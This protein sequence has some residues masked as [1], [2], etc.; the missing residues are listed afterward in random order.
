MAQSGTP[1]LNQLGQM[2][3][4]KIWVVMEQRPKYQA[5]DSTTSVGLR[6]GNDTSAYH[7]VRPCVVG[8]GQRRVAARASV[9]SCPTVALLEHPSQQHI[10]AFPSIRQAEGSGTPILLLRQTC[11]WVGG[12]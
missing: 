6:S 8:F 1:W 7:G 10:P 5:L 11:G 12:C 9:I 4:V 3:W 2:A